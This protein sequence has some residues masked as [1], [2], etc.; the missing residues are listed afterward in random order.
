MTKGYSVSKIICKHYVPPSPAAPSIPATS[1]HSAS[2]PPRRT[3]CSPTSR[4]SHLSIAQTLASCVLLASAR[5][6]AV[7]R[8]RYPAAFRRLPANARRLP[9]ASSARCCCLQRA[10]RRSALP[11]TAVKNAD[12]KCNRR[13]RLRQL[14]RA[15]PQPKS[16]MR[17]A[18]V[19]GAARRRAEAAQRCHKLRVLRRPAHGDGLAVGAVAAERRGDAA[20]VPEVLALGLSSLSDGILATTEK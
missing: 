12:E 10:A 6:A 19:L 14:R 16:S 15:L 1:P 20:H 9:T 17:R 2:A 4:G 13:V 8:A 7:R 3:A 5:A 18:G 11:P